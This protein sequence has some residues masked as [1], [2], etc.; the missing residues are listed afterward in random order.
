MIAGKLIAVRIEPFSDVTNLSISLQTGRP[1]MIERGHFFDAVEGW[2]RSPLATS[3]D[4]LLCAFVSLR[5]L[6]ADVP[7]LLRPRDGGFHGHVENHRPLMK[8]M[9]N[10][11]FRWQ[12]QWTVALDRGMNPGTTLCKATLTNCRE[13][14][15]VSDIILWRTYS[16]AALLPSF[17]ILSFLQICAD[18]HGGPSD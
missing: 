13:M 5:L 3:C 18:G 11:I 4:G 12:R 9:E 15:F 17:T 1:R 10:Q 14:S 7:G 16:L 2:Y 8:T 6:T